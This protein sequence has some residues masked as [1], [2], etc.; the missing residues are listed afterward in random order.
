MSVLTFV[1]VCLLVGTARIA[2][3]NRWWLVYGLLAYCAALQVGAWE[4]RQD[5]YANWRRD[6]TQDS[7]RWA[8][9]MT[10]RIE[11]TQA[12]CQQVAETLA[13]LCQKM[14]EGTCEEGG[15]TDATRP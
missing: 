9:D 15:A 14:P 12:N 10:N 8:R 1:V 2:G 7:H 13:R 11:G 4:D 5:Y 3:L 6:W